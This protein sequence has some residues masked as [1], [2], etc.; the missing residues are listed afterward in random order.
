ML[1]GAGAACG[2]F[3]SSTTIDAVLGRSSAAKA[4]GS[5]F[6]GKQLPVR[7][8]DLELVLVARR[9]MPGT[10]ISQK[11]LPRTRMAWRRPSQK[12]K[13]PT[14]LTRRAF[15]ANTT[16]ATPSTPSSTIGCAPSL[17]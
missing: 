16:K 3:A 10:K 15:G 8:D 7:A 5:D 12:L 9:G 2:S 6:S 1:A 14:T 13:S 11:P 17:S 4:T